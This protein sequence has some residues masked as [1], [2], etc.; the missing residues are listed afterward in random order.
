MTTDSLTRRL[1]RLQAKAPADVACVIA[2]EET[3]EEAAARWRAEH[4]GRNP[5]ILN[6]VQWG[7]E[8]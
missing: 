8:Q 2:W 1:D 5:D 3:P 7:T 6:I 4:P